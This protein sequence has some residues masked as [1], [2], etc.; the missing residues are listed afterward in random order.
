MTVTISDKPSRG[1]TYMVCV[2]ER[3][4]CRVGMQLACLKAKARGGAVT[5]LHVVPPADFQTLGAVAERMREEREKEGND[6]L[7]ALASDAREQYGMNPRRLLCEGSAGD[8]IVEMAM[9][10][11]AIIMLVLGVAHQHSSRGKL[12]AWLGGQLGG[13]LLIPL[14]MVPGNLTDQQLSTLI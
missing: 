13:K 8:K 9:N 1:G 4:E 5:L 11:P 7:E 3:P 2:D 10:D 12:A 14:L 6:L